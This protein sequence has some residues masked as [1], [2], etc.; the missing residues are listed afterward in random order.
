MHTLSVELAIFFR[1]NQFIFA[2]IRVKETPTK[3]ENFMLYEN[4]NHVKQNT[5]M[6]PKIR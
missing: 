6:A 3:K 4:N 1:H 5:I 2:L